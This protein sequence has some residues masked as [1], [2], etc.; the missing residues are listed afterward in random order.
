MR[1]RIHGQM[2][3]SPDSAALFAMLFDF[4][5]TFA[6]DVQPGGINHQIRDFTPRGRFKTDV[7]RLCPLADTAVIRATRRS[8]H[9]KTL[10]ASDPGRP[11]I[12]L[13][14]TLSR[15]P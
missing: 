4:P 5:L 7:N 15:F 11:G 13:A 14:L 1:L 3:F 10:V 12:Y 8:G 6:E 2:Q 9:E